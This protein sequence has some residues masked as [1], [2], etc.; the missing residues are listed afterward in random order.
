MK[1]ALMVDG[2]AAMFPNP[3]IETVI[4]QNGDDRSTVK[5]T[6]AEWL[7]SAEDWNL[8]DASA[9]AAPSS[10]SA[11]REAATAAF[12]ALRSYQ[13]GNAATELA[14]QAADNLEAALAA[15]AGSAGKQSGGQ[16]D[17]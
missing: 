14:K 2:L 15:Q 11:L 3:M 6:L 8:P 4:D 10:V 13:Y 5:V 16:H 17:S 9:G 12:H 1:L 7:R